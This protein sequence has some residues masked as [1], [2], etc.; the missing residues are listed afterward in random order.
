MSAPAGR[1]PTAVHAPRPTGEPCRA[2]P[3]V[4]AVRDQPGQ[5]TLLDTL[6]TTAAGIVAHLEDRVCPADPAS[7][8]RGWWW[9]RRGPPPRPLTG[10][11]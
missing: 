9:R 8:R 2:P 3:E 5:V 6:E 7:A 10:P 11:T 4:P 1:R